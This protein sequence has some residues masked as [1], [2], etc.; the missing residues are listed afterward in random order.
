MWNILENVSVNPQD[1]YAH[2]ASFRE[3]FIN[4]RGHSL[5]R[6]ENQDHITSGEVSQWAEESVKAAIYA[7]KGGDADLALLQQAENN[8]HG[9]VRLGI[10]DLSTGKPEFNRE[11][12]EELNKLFDKWKEETARRKIVLTIVAASPYE[13]KDEIKLATDDANLLALLTNRN[14]KALQKSLFELLANRNDKG[15]DPDVPKTFLLRDWRE[16]ILTLA[17]A[18]EK[19]NATVSIWGRVLK[20][21]NRG[22]YYLYNSASIRGALPVGDWRIELR[23][24]GKL[25]ESYRKLRGKNEPDWDFLPNDGDSHN[26]HLCNN[27]VMLYLQPDKIT[28]RR[29][30]GDTFG[31]HETLWP[32]ADAPRSETVW[33]EIPD[34]IQTFIQELTAAENSR[35]T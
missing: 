23:P 25:S 26:E 8:L 18:E 16:S 27:T 24:D 2:I 13:L 3:Q 34:T 11:R 15:H 20:K 31:D 29:K 5:Y 35:N 1:P 10:F 7:G 4:R 9:R 22:G 33:E 6:H 21:H 12:L 32:Q 14:D 19:K 28:V 30:K 17:E